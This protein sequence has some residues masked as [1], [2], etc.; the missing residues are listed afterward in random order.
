MKNGVEKIMK[1]PNGATVAVVDG[2]HMLLF[3][4]KGHEPLIELDD[5]PKV[6]VTSINSNS[7]N[8]H[9]SSAANPDANRLAEDGF[10]AAVAAFLNSAVL[11]GDIRKLLVI[12]DPRTLGEMRPQFHGHLIAALVGEIPRDLVRHSKEDIE[13]AIRA[14]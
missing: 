14:A 11:A 7:G 12:A 10:A 8:R 1:L 13:A 9:R 2:Q 5:L 4:N 6:N 3:R